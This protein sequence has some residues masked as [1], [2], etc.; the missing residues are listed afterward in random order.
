VLI[1]FL[2]DRLFIVSQQPLEMLDLEVDPLLAAHD[3][4][5]G[6]PLRGAERLEGAGVKLGC[7]GVAERMLSED[8]GH[9]RLVS[10][11]RRQCNRAG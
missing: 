8:K 9:D 4:K 6:D 3:G 7:E 2:R 1:D 5:I 11:G 10:V